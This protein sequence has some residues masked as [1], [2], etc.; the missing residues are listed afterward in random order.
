MGTF[1]TLA[2]TTNITLLALIDKFSTIS[3]DMTTNINNLAADITSADPG[4]FLQLQFGMSQVT[5][6]GDS[7]S[8]MI[9]QI[10]NCIKTAVSNQNR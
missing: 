5:Q 8:N 7:I 4:K 1:A 3:A 9:A 10:N 6:V 2:K